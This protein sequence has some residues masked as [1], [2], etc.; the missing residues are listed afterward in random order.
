MLATPDARH[1]Q[2]RS[3]REMSASEPMT[4]AAA[5]VMLVM[6]MAGTLNWCWQLSNNNPSDDTFK[7]RRGQ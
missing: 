4:A 3:K 5:A 2:S 7:F 1:D 6:T